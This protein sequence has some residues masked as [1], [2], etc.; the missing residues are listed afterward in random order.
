MSSLFS[1]V[2]VSFSKVWFD[3]HQC[4]SGGR[5]NLPT[6][7]KIIGSFHHHIGNNYSNLW[8][9]NGK[10]AL[11]CWGLNDLWDKM[12]WHD[13]EGPLL[14]FHLAASLCVC[15]VCLQGNT[16]SCTWP[17]PIGK[18]GQYGFSCE[19]SVSLP[20]CSRIYVF[21]LRFLTV[22]QCHKE[23]IATK[24]ATDGTVPHRALIS[25]SSSP[26]DIKQKVRLTLPHV[27]VLIFLIKNDSSTQLQ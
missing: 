21:F 23:G 1:V 26:C 12:K 25:A 22:L 10:C 4:C 19:R 13:N 9:F 11:V 2:V 24:K 6:K 14:S 8:C 15:C 17:M 5:I 7:R 20:E 18:T 27:A 16:K 3:S